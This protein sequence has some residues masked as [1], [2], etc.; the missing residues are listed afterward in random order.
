M[1]IAKVG[2]NCLRI[3]GKNATIIVDP[4]QKGGPADIALAL[5]KAFSF[6]PT[7]G[8]RLTVVGAG[9]YEVGGVKVSGID[10]G[11]E[12]VYAGEIDGTRFVLGYCLAIEKTIS[13]L[14]ETPVAI[15]NVSGSFNPSI[16]AALSP[17][18]CVLYGPQIEEALAALGKKDLPKVSKYS[19]KVD[20]LA[21]EGE[22]I[23]VLD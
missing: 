4:S 5:K 10:G 14:D 19:V 12:L 17:Q 22:E 6:P 1:E 11:A 8:V 20:K 7:Q 15:I 9:E 13:S 21:S 16:I 3:K 23:V 18:V 2:E